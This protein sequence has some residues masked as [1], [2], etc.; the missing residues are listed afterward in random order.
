M[1]FIVSPRVISIC[2][3]DNRVLLIKRRDDS[4][5]SGFYLPIGGHIEPNETMIEASDREFLEEAGLKAQNT[6][7]KG[8]LHQTG[9]YGKDVVLFITL[10]NAEDG[11]LITSEEGVPEWIPLPDLHKYKLLGNSVTMIETCQKL[12]SNE[13]F[14]AIS[15]FD[16]HDKELEFKIQIHQIS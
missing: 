5:F 8:I 9:F 13:I 6:K 7:L 3:K 10:W 1:P 14:I 15:K 12:K 16:G 4:Q 2:I 11:E